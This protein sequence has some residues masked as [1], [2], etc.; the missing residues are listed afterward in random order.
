MGEGQCVI[1]AVHVDGLFTDVVGEVGD[2]GAAAIPR[3]LLVD[4]FFLG[5]N[6]YLHTEIE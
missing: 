4:G 6:C 3:G 1:G 2:V 5:I